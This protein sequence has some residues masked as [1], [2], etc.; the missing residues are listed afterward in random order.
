MAYSFGGQVVQNEVT[1][2]VR[3]PPAVIKSMRKALSLTYVCLA[4][5]YFGV[6]VCE[7]AGRVGFGV[8]WLWEG[9]RDCRS[10]CAV[11]EAGGPSLLRGA[12]LHPARQA[13]QCTGLIQLCALASDQ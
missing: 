6:A 11:E 10:K 4:V 9:R 13:A 5:C 3:T 7:W 8:G 1:A 12:L 2:M